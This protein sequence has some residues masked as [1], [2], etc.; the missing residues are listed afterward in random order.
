MI[1]VKHMAA[2]LAV[3]WAKDGVRV[4]SL[5]CASPFNSALNDIY[6]QMKPR[7]HVNEAYEEY[8]GKEP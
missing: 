5:R 7:L 1:A 3:E 8:I 4:N 2:S 6:V